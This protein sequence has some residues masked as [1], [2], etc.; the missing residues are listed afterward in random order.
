[1]LLRVICIL[2][3]STMSVV[4]TGEIDLQS[5]IIKNRF[6]FIPKN[7]SK[8]RRNPG[9][10]WDFLMIFIES[11]FIECS[12][13][14]SDSKFHCSTC[15]TKSIVISYFELFFQES[16]EES[17]IV[18]FLWNIHWFW[19]H[20]GLATWFCAMAISYNIDVVLIFLSRSLT[21]LF[22]FN[23]VDS[24]PMIWYDQSFTERR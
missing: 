8:I 4:Y 14:K 21:S 3:A 20:I 22:I 2:L 15:D 19:V 12:D 11:M 13:S 17:A 5:F 1:M 9:S 16:L 24:T 10:I 18:I 7:Y 23:S 6:N